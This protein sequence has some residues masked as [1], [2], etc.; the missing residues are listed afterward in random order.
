MSLAPK[1]TPDVVGF[2]RG[3]RFVGFELKVEGDKLSAT[4]LERRKLQAEWRE[5]IVKAGGICEQISTP[6]EAL[7]ALLSAENLF[8]SKGLTD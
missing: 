3:G 2:T 6:E 5:K 8:S 1:G 4:K 7:A